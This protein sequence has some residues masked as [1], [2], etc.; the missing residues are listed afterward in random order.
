[1]LAYA[2]GNG[3]PRSDGIWATA[4]SALAGTDVTDVDIARTLE[5]A[6]PYIMEDTEF[7]QAV[8]RLAHRTFAEHYW[9]ADSHDDR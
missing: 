8:Y 2:R 1:M 7:G 6:A 3:F 9:A 5:L 4:G